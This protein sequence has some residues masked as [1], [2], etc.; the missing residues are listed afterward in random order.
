MLDSSCKK[1]SCPPSREG[2]CTV[3]FWIYLA[4]VGWERRSR[5]STENLGSGKLRSLCWSSSN[6]HTTT[7]KLRVYYVQH[8]G[9][10]Q[11]A[12]EI[13]EGAVSDCSPPRGRSASFFCTH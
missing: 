13:S 6:Y 8:S 7:Q 2:V 12:D 3:S 5:H 4:G 10:G 9:R 1:F 11:L